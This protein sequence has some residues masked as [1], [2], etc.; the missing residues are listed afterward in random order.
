MFLAAILAAG[1]GPIFLIAAI[2]V[3]VTSLILAAADISASSGNSADA[4][5]ICDT[6]LKF[7]GAISA[8]TVL[9]EAK[10]FRD[11]IAYLL[12]AVRAFT[13]TDIANAYCARI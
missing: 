12:A 10:V 3:F 5:A 6:A 13:Y 4:K 1:V 9:L 8:A 2:A 11:A 7:F